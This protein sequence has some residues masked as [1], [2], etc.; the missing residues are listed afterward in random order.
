MI[1]YASTLQSKKCYVV[2]C[3]GW[4]SGEK[5]MTDGKRY[6]DERAFAIELNS[7]RDLKNVN[8]TNW[9]EHIVLE[10]SIGTLKH[11]DFVEGIV[12]ELVGTEGVLR[13]DFSKG[14]MTKTLQS[15]DQE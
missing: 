5:A 9:A 10:G 14:D 4:Y 15:L 2:S 3:G 1:V 13:V 7:G 6:D 8:F 12:L 11:A